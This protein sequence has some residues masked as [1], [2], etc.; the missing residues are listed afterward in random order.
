M[1]TSPFSAVELQT[2]NRPPL[3]ELLVTRGFITQ[4]QL[5]Q[6]REH[7]IQIGHRKLIGEILRDFNFVTEQQL[8][9]G[10][11]RELRRAVRG[12]DVSRSPIH[13]ASSSCPATSS[14]ST[15]CCRSSSFAAS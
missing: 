3:G 13:A 8:V 7:Q 15:R 5:D 6:A 11:G 10:A 1:T 12:A 14:K 2:M 9:S 4:K